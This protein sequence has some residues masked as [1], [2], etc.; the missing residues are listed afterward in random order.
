MKG[1][2]C[3]VLVDGNGH[4]LFISFGIVLD[5]IC[6]CIQSSEPFF[7]WGVNVASRVYGNT[8]ERPGYVCDL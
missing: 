4:S 3:S 6:V 2:D 7:V 5:Y 8:Y 1:K